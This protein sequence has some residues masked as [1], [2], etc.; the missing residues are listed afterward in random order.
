MGSG[1]WLRALPTD[2]CLG[3]AQ[4]GRE[5]GF[6]PAPGRA[7]RVGAAPADPPAPGG[8]LRQSRAGHGSA[9]RDR[10][11]R[12]DR[13]ST[14]TQREGM[15]LHTAGGEG[16][17]RRASGDEVVP[18][19]CCLMTFSKWSSLSIILKVSPSSNFFSEIGSCTFT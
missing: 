19:M 14:H 16:R 3:N 17:G 13:H 11:D 15:E 8:L 12:H 4:A 5:P 7:P 6:A 9:N 18:W 2:P 10:H 1:S